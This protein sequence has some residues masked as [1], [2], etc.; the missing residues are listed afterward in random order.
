MAVALVTGSS[1]GIG[2]GI[3]QALVQ[4]GY[5]VALNGCTDQVQLDHAVKALEGFG[6][7]MG[8][9]ADVSDYQ[10]TQNMFEDIRQRLGSVDVVVNNAGEG[11]F[12]LFTDM[13]PEAIH[14]MIATNLHTAM[15]VSHVALPYMLRQKQGHIINITSIWGLV[16]ASCEVAYATAKAGVV[17]F[18]KALAKEVAPSGVKV[19]AIACGA[20]ETRMNQRLTPEEKAAFTEGIPMGRFGQPYEVGDLVV[21]LASNKSQY[22][23]GQ[24]I[25]LD[26]GMI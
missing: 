22:L 20:F 5:K 4:H 9:L 1:R 8:V 13:P 2:F 17:G 11:H 14:R 10:S 6:D 21:F 25:T 15:H 24:V 12:D 18:T 26:G 19:N 3:A 23:T 7:V 16:G